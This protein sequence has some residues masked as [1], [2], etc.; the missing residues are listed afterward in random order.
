MIVKC[1][2]CQVWYDDEFR[3]THCPHDTFAANDG[4]NLFTHHP[5]SYWSMGPPSAAPR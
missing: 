5:E 4:R 1:L 3:W 2:D